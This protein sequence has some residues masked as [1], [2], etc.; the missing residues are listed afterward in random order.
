MATHPLQSMVGKLHLLPREERK[1]SHPNEAACQLLLEE[2]LELADYIF[3]G[4]HCSHVLALTLASFVALSYF[5]DAQ[6]QFSPS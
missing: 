2:I 5:F 6:A 3:K 1:R 4:D